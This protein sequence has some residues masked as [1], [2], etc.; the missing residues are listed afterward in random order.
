MELWNSA[1]AHKPGAV[2]LAAGASE[3]MG[4]HKPFLALNGRRMLECAVTALLGAGASDIVVVTG[5][6]AKETSAYARSLGARAAENLNYLFTDMAESIRIGLE[7]LEP[8]GPFFVLPCD[9]PLVQPKTLGLLHTA[10]KATGAEAAVPVCG[11]QPGHPP[12]FREDCAEGILSFSGEGGLAAYLEGLAS[13]ASV[14]V[15]DEACLMDADTPEAYQAMEAYA[16]AHCGFSR[17]IALRFA[18]SAG[19]SDEERRRMA[20]AEGKAAN[21]AL[22]LISESVPVDL[23]LLSSACLTSLLPGSAQAVRSEGYAAVADLVASIP[24]PKSVEGMAANLALRLA[25][26]QQDAGEQESVKAFLKF[27]VDRHRKGQL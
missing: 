21:I 24:A 22:R 3:R 9:M 14:E 2:V 5:R 27:A 6:N 8:Q 20:L 15:G 26:G 25:T 7:A 11:G 10:I 18:E 23:S 4:E 13:Q 1:P 12:M 16:K 17:E 19:I